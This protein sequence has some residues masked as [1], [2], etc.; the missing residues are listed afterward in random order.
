[1]RSVSFDVPRRMFRVFRFDVEVESCRLRCTR[2]ATVPRGLAA[3]H[4]LRAA[5]RRSKGKMERR[6]N[7]AFEPTRHFDGSDR[8]PGDRPTCSLERRSPCENQSDATRQSCLLEGEGLNSFEQ[9]VDGGWNGERLDVAVRQSKF[10]EVTEQF[11]LECLAYEKACVV[12]AKG[13]ESGSAP[14]RRNAHDR[15]QTTNPT[16]WRDMD[17]SNQHHA[18]PT[19][20]VANEDRRRSHG[21]GNDASTSR[22]RKSSIGAEATRLLKRWM[23]QNYMHPYPSTEEKLTLMEQTSLN[24]TQLDNWFINA[25]ARI[26]KKLVEGVHSEHRER[27]QKKEKKDP[28]LK[29]LLEDNRRVVR[30]G[31][32][33][34]GLTTDAACSSAL[35]R[36]ASDAAQNCASRSRS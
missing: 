35:A 4:V 24:S 26:W 10:F 29:A 8:D 1:M 36:A 9:G 11:L 14:P 5:N 25:R 7:E 19:T 3:L 34:A 31:I 23:F 27:L 6:P 22:G 21:K 33:L 16:L 13:K 2:L 18:R 30:T 17:A 32:I 12:N 15:N 20:I 28:R